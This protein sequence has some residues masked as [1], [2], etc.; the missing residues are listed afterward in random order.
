MTPAEK[1]PFHEKALELAEQHKQKYPDY[2]YKPRRRPK[3][4]K[5]MSR[6][7]KKTSQQPDPLS[8]PHAEHS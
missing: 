8:S 4:A 2:K 3:E 5:K 7:G 1:Q 6:R